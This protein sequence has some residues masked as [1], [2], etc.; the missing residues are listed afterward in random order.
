MGRVPHGAVFC[1]LPP[2]Y[3]RNVAAMEAIR[4]DA[5]HA[6]DEATRESRIAWEA[7]VVEF[8]QGTVNVCFVG[9]ANA[10]KSSLLNTVLGGQSDGQWCRTNVKAET[11][12]CTTFKFNSAGEWAL[13]DEARQPGGKFWLEL[14]QLQEREC[15]SQCDKDD[16]R[17]MTPLAPFLKIS[18]EARAVLVDTPGMSENQR[19]HDA[20]VN[21][22]KSCP[23]NEVP[24]LVYCVSLVSGVSTDPG[25]ELSLQDKAF[26]DA[27]GIPPHRIIVVASHFDMFVDGQKNDDDYEEVEVDDSFFAVHTHTQTSDSEKIK[28]AT[29]SFQKWAELIRARYPG[30]HVLSSAK[31]D[32]SDRLLPSQEVRKIM[33]YDIRKAIAA[34]IANAHMDVAF[35]YHTALRKD[36]AERLAYVLTG[37]QQALKTYATLAQDIVQ[38]STRKFEQINADLLSTIQHQQDKLVKANGRYLKRSSFHRDLMTAVYDPIAIM[39]KQHCSTVIELARA[40]VASRIEG[41]LANTRVAVPHLLAEPD[42]PLEELWVSYLA[43]FVAFVA[44]EALIPVVGAAVVAG[45][46]VRTYKEAK[47]DYPSVVGEIH[48]DYVQALQSPLSTFK[49]RLQTMLEQAVL[50][51]SNRLHKN[52]TFVSEK[53]RSA[54]DNLLAEELCCT[55]LLHVDAL[56]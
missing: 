1:N 25:S 52:S 55:L 46:A 20:V 6:C 50:D 29:D 21:R 4:R 28:M 24:V 34:C 38:T 12:R 44:M 32:G 31:V 7:P 22:L 41:G 3:A 5:M 18:E 51:A 26:I 43:G 33:V 35:K 9:T 15:I 10:G 53:L 56:T 54:G 49:D 45:V 36:V 39:F 30:I 13:G 40:E 8:K 47:W 37:S 23:G 42:F 16:L 2:D 11:A 17:V 14:S 27:T 19:L 48:K